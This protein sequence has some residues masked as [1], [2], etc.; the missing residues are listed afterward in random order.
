MRLKLLEPHIIADAYRA[1]GTVLDLPQGYAVTPL[2]EGLDDEARAAVDYA[3]LL[4]WGRFPWP[5]GL[6]PP[7]GAPL[8]SPPI[9]RPIDD[10][11]PVF[12]FT[13]NKEYL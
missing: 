12:H 10:N 5:Y 7:S 1:K 6:Y 13:G 11:Q 8:D 4:A 9:P 3:K 2:M